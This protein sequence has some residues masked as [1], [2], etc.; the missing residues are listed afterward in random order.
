M[1]SNNVTSD[2]KSVLTT[3][4][5]GLADATL[6]RTTQS[7]DFKPIRAEL[8]AATLSVDTAKTALA[9]ARAA[10]NQQDITYYTNLLAQQ[11]KRLTS[12][13]KAVESA[14]DKIGVTN[15]LINGYKKQIDEANTQIAKQ[16]SGTA[17]G[18]NNK[19]A[20]TT[21]PASSNPGNPNT[22]T[23]PT[24]PPVAAQGNTSVA[25]SSVASG[26]KAAVPNTT[27]SEARPNTSS[28]KIVKPA[29]KTITTTRTVTNDGIPEALKNAPVGS[30]WNRPGSSDGKIK[31]TNLR[32]V[33]P[34]QFVAFDSGGA[35]IKLDAAGAA[36]QFRTKNYTSCNNPA[37]MPKKTTTQVK[38]KK[39]VPATKGA[40]TQTTP[41]VPGEGGDYTVK[42]GDT[43]SA[44]AKAYGL[45]LQQLLEANPQIKNPNLIKVGQVIKIPGK[46]EENPQFDDSD[47]ALATDI[48]TSFDQANFEAFEDWRVRLSLA[49]GADYL[50]AGK[51]PGILQP[52]RS[53]QGVV[54]PY[55]PTIQ[56]NYQAN[57]NGIDVTHSNYKVFQYS[58]SSV[59]SVTISCDFTAQDA[60]EARYL[61]A[62]IH[63]FKSMTKMF[64]GQDTYPIR[65]TPPPLCYMYGLGGYQFSAHPLAIRDFNYN[66]PNDVDYIQTTTPSTFDTSPTDSDWMNYIMNRVPDSVSETRLGEQCTVGA[67]PPPPRFS[68][69]P[70]DI[71]TYVPTKIQL[72][73]S[74]VPIMSRNQISNYF[75]LDDYASGYL[76]K[77]TSRPGGGM[78]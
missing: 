3:A 57:Y 30:Q 28:N 35:P 19:I 76:V 72:S 12:A 9:T 43:L 36:K 25:T 5:Q 20:A 31:A 67:G 38:E 4:Q 34:N 10:G 37:F 53:T 78:W 33:G 2:W 71:T 18:T 62:V 54:F 49:P 47:I 22:A 69:L 15:D 13:K 50:Y 29:T 65:G 70:R 42:K 6:M 64:Y 52:L 7:E 27:T 48:Q 14:V 24:T 39:V 58:S 74:C 60:Y 63:F 56:V 21:T 26:T 46:E 17:P 59:D 1:A 55:T 44:I 23:T 45:T 32:K 75:S 8:A 41:V 51:N 40:P 68:N 66:L 77:G 11:E 61:L 73:I 16:A